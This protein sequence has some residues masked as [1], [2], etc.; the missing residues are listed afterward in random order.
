MHVNYLAFWDLIARDVANFTMLALS[1]KLDS[2]RR[3]YT[4]R[5]LVHMQTGI[6]S[7]KGGNQS[8]NWNTEV[9]KASQDHHKSRKEFRIHSHKDSWLVVA[10]WLVDTMYI[11]KRWSSLIWFLVTLYWKHYNGTNLKV[12]LLKSLLKRQ[13]ALL[14]NL[15]LRSTCFKQCKNTTFG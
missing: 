9:Q 2:C 11:Q 10:G 7:Y 6:Y 5:R 8:C 15:A 12:L 13:W 3:K 14:T 4:C 1:R